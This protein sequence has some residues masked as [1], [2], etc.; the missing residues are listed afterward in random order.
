MIDIVYEDNHIIAVNKE[1]G[2]LVQADKTNDKCLLEMVKEFI[3]KRDNKQGN[4]FLGLAHRIDRPTS[5]LV[6][7]AKTSKALTRLSNMFREKEIEKYY[8][9][10]VD[11]VIEPT[12]GT[13]NNYLIRKPKFN[14]SFVCNKS[15][16]GS[17]EAKLKYEYIK[18]GS[19]YYLVK[20]Q[21]LTGRHH[22]IRAQFSN[23]DVHIKGDLKYGASRSNKDG[24]ISLHSYQMK[25]IHPVSQKSLTLTASVPKENIWQN[26]IS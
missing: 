2:V 6:L 18:K 11:N 16:K 4:V 14:K 25:F 15:V 24:G 26:L 21:L 13:L 23:Y 22:Q 19:T 1:P 17:K 10:L 5:G 20:I 8:L 3:K 12:S 7:F 9:A